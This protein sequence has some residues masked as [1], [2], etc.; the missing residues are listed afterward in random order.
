MRYL[1]TIAFVFFVLTVKAQNNI[2]EELKQ[3]GLWEGTVTIHQDPS[4]TSLIGTPIKFDKSGKKEWKAR[5]YRV[6]VYAGD[7][8]RDA[9][10]MAYNVAHKV[11]AEFPDV[12][13]YTYFLPPRW[14]C[15]VGDFRS[16]EE[17][18]AIMRKLKATG[19][20]KEVS[21]VREQI[22]ISME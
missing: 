22:N 8:S 16:V 9:R 1:F 14:L 6:Q 20:F 2:F 21:I 19:F 11:E 13:V 7:N 12:P 3:S 5:G 17:A 4:I 15:R 18:Y 10:S